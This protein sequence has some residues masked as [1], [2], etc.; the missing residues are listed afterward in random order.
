MLTLFV[1]AGLLLLHTN[2][3]SLLG[4]P[5]SSAIALLAA[6]F[7]AK[8][9]EILWLLQRVEGISETT[10]RVETGI[11]MVG[12]FALAGVLAVVTDRD[13]APYFVLLAIPIL[14]CA[15]HF[16]F[17]LTLSTV[18]A[19]IA[20]IFGWAFHFFAL[21]PPPRA[22]EFLESG[23]ISLIYALMG[24]L[25]WS[26]V[27]QL[28][29]KECLLFEQMSELESA[30]QTLSREEKLAAVGRLASGIAH[31]IRNPVAMIVSSLATAADSDPL[32]AEREEMFEIAKR[33]AKRLEVLTTDFLSY[34]RPSAPQK[35]PT[36]IAEI[37]QHVTNATRLRAHSK[38]IHVESGAW[39][40][41]TADIDVVQ[42]ESALLNICLNAVEATP[43]G[44]T[45]ALR[46]NL[47]SDTL[48]VEIENTGHAIL[49]ENLS[50]IFE[51]FFTTRRSGTGL[52]LAIAKRVAEAHGGAVWV[53]NNMNGSVIFTFSI[54]VPRNSES[55]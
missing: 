28:R 41:I 40:Q 34:A 15:Y 35:A 32:P 12:M 23:M 30:H 31:E 27:D 8:L 47:A 18:L 2:F 24:I 4:E 6:C 49:E 5:P 19:S 9:M 36:P 43:E 52:G 17:A 42:I 7:V 16:G 20:M 45:I 44:G 51:P 46:S 37:L 3:E 26:L 21:H 38:G 10:A 48:S 13:D 54:R 39:D 53:S 25:V 55:D 22:T 29:K 1:T 14:Q 50:K 11:S 33:E